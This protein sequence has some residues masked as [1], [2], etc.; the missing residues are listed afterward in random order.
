LKIAIPPFVSEI[1][2][3]AFQGVQQVTSESSDFPVDEAGVLFDLKNK[4]LLYAPPALSGT[5][6]VPEGISEIEEGAFTG[7]QNLT[8]VV[9]PRGITEIKSGTFRKCQNLTE[10]LIPDTVVKI[11][12]NAFAEC[13]KLTELIIPD[14]V[15]ELSPSAFLNAGCVKKLK[16]SYP[17]LLM[18]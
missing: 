8:G 14:S 10:I 18:R 4:K 1:R 12:D 2:E 16:K 6:A 11:G 3:F 13:Q 9:L 17:E 7:C 5:Y 15:V